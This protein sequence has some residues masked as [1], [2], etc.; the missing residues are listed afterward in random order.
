V[1]SKPK[2]RSPSRGSAEPSQ[3]PPPKP[4]KHEVKSKPK[5]RSPSQSPPPKKPSKTEEAKKIVER[6]KKQMP[7]FK[8][9]EKKPEKKGR[10][11]DFFKA[12]KIVYVSDDE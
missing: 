1:K 6:S 11:V 9:E 8:D 3:S 4:G 10:I 12:K 2:P 5:P 7:F